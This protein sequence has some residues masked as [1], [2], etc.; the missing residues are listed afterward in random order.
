MPNKPAIAPSTPSA[1]PETPLPL[2]RDPL[3][4]YASARAAATAAVR[5]HVDLDSN[6]FEAGTETSFGIDDSLAVRIAKRSYSVE[7]T[8]GESEYLYSE[9]AFLCGR[10]EELQGGSEYVAVYCVDTGGIVRITENRAHAEPPRPPNAPELTRFHSG[11]RRILEE[12]PDV[13]LTSEG[14]CS[15]SKSYEPQDLGSATYTPTSH[16]N[17][18]VE[19]CS[20]WQNLRDKA[21]EVRITGE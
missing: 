10:D 3:E 18:S 21:A 19:L 2:Q 1:P 14:A 13:E 5:Y 9:G 8:S 12:L 17:I 11:A 16:V 4:R 7:G 15:S 20:V 6:D